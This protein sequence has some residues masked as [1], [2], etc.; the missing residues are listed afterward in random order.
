MTISFS[1]AEAIKIQT[2]QLDFYLKSFSPEAAASIRQQITANNAKAVTGFDIKRGVQ[3]EQLVWKARGH[4]DSDY[5]S[6]LRSMD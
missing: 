2:E 1:V 3:I 5:A 4:S 6:Y